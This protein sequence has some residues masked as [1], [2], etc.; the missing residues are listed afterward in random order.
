[1]VC[2]SIMSPASLEAVET[3]W[4]PEVH[5]HCPCVP[6]VLV[7]TKLDLSKDET[8]EAIPQE[9]AEKVAERIGA[10]KH[11]RLSALTQQGLNAAFEETVRV[12]IGPPA[13]KSSRFCVLL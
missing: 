8:G 9:E 5:H 7:G 1:M 12:V 2:Y 10:K 4:V 13:P 11:V 6:L 3:K